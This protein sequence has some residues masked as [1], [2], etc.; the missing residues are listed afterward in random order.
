MDHFECEMKI[1][2]PVCSGWLFLKVFQFYQTYMS[3][4]GIVYIIKVIP[5]YL[6]FKSG[7]VHNF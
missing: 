5:S 3:V 6:T 4:E 1:G 2:Y 7:E